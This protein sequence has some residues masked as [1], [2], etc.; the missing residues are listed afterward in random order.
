M[1][2]PSLKKQGI[3]YLDLAYKFFILFTFTLFNEHLKLGNNE[4]L[5]CA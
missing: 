3:Q 5:C 1:L 4:C 2:F